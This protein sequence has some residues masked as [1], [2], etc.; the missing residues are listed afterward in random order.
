MPNMIIF[1]INVKEIQNVKVW[2]KST[3]SITANE[4]ELHHKTYPLS[5]TLLTSLFTVR[6]EEIGRGVQTDEY[7]L[8]GLPLET[9]KTY[10]NE[11]WSPG[12]IDTLY[13]IPV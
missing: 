13:L 9:M 2:A 1:V 6:K 12:F 7:N 10:M 5:N 8:K 11:N 3:L 4:K